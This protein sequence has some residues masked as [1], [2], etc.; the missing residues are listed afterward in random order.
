VVDSIFPSAEELAAAVAASAAAAGRV[1]APS[2]GSVAGAFVLP[3]VSAV[4]ARSFGSDVGVPVPASA[5]DSGVAD[6]ASGL[7]CPAVAGI[8]GR[9]WDSP[10]WE[11][12]GVRA[13]ESP[14]RA[15]AREER[16]SRDEQPP[17]DCPGSPGEEHYSL[18]EPAQCRPVPP[19]DG[20][21]LLLLSRAP[22][23]VPLILRA[24][25]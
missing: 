6:F 15:L 14:K 25:R 5:P 21:A 11:E 4:Q 7:T 1:F 12:Q 23:Q 10:C 17:A 20:M 8:S 19:E 16:C 9:V 13:L 3:A 2:V 22:L 24:C 18:D